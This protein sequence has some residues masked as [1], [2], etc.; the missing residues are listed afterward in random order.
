MNLA[1]SFRPNLIELRL[2]FIRGLDIERLGAI[3]GHLLGN[4]IL[5]IRSRKEDG[6]LAISDSE[7][8]ELIR[9][10][11]YQL[12]PSIVD[13]EISTIRKFPTL[14]QDLKKTKSKL[15]AS[16]HDLQGTKTEEYLRKMV[17]FAP[18]ELKSSLFG[19]KIVSRARKLEDN[20]KVLNLYRCIEHSSKLVAFCLGKQGVPSRILSFFLGAPFGY[21]SLPGEPVAYGQM[22][23]EIM[24]RLLK[25]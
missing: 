18:H 3:R 6:Q 22:D 21:S 24:R 12:R 19:V 23:I 8:A 17:A 11:M 2:D 7:R 5:T 14:L 13:I 10:V 25:A 16:F 9:Y 1:R 4:E 15:V 20:L